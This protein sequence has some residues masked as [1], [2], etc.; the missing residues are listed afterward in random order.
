MEFWFSV[1]D[2]ALLAA[3]VESKGA[4]FYGRLTSVTEDKRV[5]DLCSFF[6]EQ[7][8]Q[9]ESAFR[10]MAEGHDS[11][12]S[13]PYSV[14][15]RK[16]LETSL[17]KLSDFLSD[18]SPRAGLVDVFEV[19][20]LAEDLE[21]TSIKVYTNMLQAYTETFSHIIGRLLEEEREHLRSI[22]K[23]QHEIRATNGAMDAD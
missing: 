1:H 12:E 20:S 4:E 19:L 3:E 7:E 14:D 22:H 15:I 23:L 21:T 16:M 5:T 13:R 2:I 10:S 11:T 17:G 6:A 18:P 8:R 9:H